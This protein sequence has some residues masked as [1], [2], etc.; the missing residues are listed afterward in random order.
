MKAIMLAAS[1]LRFIAEDFNGTPAAQL[2]AV[3]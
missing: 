1:W 2:Q 3:A